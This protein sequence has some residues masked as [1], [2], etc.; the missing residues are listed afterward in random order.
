MT[1]PRKKPATGTLV[2]RQ[3]LV[4][5][6][7]IVAGVVVLAILIRPRPPEPATPD[8][9]GP[10]GE[11]LNDATTV[12]LTGTRNWSELDDPESDGWDTEV[13]SDAAQ[14]RLNAL[15]KCLAAADPVGEDEWNSFPTGGFTSSVLMPPDRT[16]VYE[17]DGLRIERAAGP[18]PGSEPKGAAGFRDTMR[19]LAE[20]FPA[21]ADLRAKFKLFKIQAEGRYFTTRQYF[22]LSGTTSDGAAAEL[23]A[24]WTIRWQNPGDD[25]ADPRLA[26]IRLDDFELAT[27]QGGL[28]FRECTPSVLAG[29][30]CYPDQILR[31]YNHWL[32]RSQD[33]E[34]LYLL[35]TPG[36]AI[37]D[38]N[39]D[40]LDDFYLCQEAGLPNCLF[41]QRPDGRVEEVGGPA[42]VDWLE[43]SRCALLLDLDNDGDQDLAVA[44]DGGVALA[45]ND[46][47]GK[48]ALRTVLD[49]H[50]DLLSLSAADCDRDGRLDL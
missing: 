45:A 26:S 9:R 40:S 11:T 15:A 2:S 21:T 43:N 44:L 24:I 19:Q 34:F 28:L 16:V 7:A 36:L 46:G 10:A 17:E 42:G 41:L 30:D 27:R 33:L 22:S 37:G 23:H 5:V 29:N 38:V 20:G 8:P 47:T 18:A 31:G 39:G 4:W 32:E 13:L 3:R 48:F 6:G 49:S 50:S 14:A 1:D 12:P 25:P 35:G